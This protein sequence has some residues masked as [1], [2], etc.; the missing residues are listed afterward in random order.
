[1]MLAAQVGAWR[2]HSK[3]PSGKPRFQRMPDGF[4]AG[5]RQ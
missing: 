3:K 4:F 1:M 2:L 5:L